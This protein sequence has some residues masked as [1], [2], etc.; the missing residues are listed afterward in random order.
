[1]EPMVCHA[2]AAPDR[3]AGTSSGGGSDA[4][5]RYKD[6]RNGR[7]IWYEACRHGIAPVL[8]NHSA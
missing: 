6:K 4:L 5:T 1:M 7:M 2:S 8:G 3:D